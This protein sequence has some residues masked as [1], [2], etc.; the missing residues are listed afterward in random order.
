MRLTNKLIT[1]LI[2][3]LFILSGCS[4]INSITNIKFLHNLSESLNIIEYKVKEPYFKNISETHE[5][6]GNI[7]S[8]VEWSILNPEDDIDFND[9]LRY[10]FIYDTYVNLFE[11]KSYQEFMNE[12]IENDIILDNYQTNDIVSKKDMN[13]IINFIKFKMNNPI[14]EPINNIN[15]KEK[16]IYYENKNDIFN[17]NLKQGQLVSFKDNYQTTVKRINLDNNNIILDDVNL[18]EIIKDINIENN[19]DIDFSKSIIID[20]DNNVIK[21]SNIEL[22]SMLSNNFTYKGYY[23]SY[24]FSN[25]TFNVYISKN[26]DKLNYY[27]EF[28][29]YSINMAY[30]FR[31]NDHKINNAFLK[32]SYDSNIKTGISVGKYYD[33]FSNL[34]FNKGDNILE[35]VISSFQNQAELDSIKIP[36]AT[37]KI[38]VPGTVVC[39]IVLKLQVHLYANGKMEFSIINDNEVGFEIKNSNIR[40]INDI[41]T[42]LDFNLRSSANTSLNVLLGLQLMSK[43][44]I[45]LSL[46]TGIKGEA[47][48]I[49]HIYDN[50]NINSYNLDIPIDVLEEKVKDEDVSFCSDL[51]LYYITYL[52]FNSD[53]TLAYNLGFNKVI[54]ILDE[55]NQVFNNEFTHI[56]NFQF[57]K[58]CSK[59]KNYKNEQL[60]VL[61]TNKFVLKK[62]QYII[63]KDSIQNLN[64]ISIPKGYNK[65]DIIIEVDNP[66]IATVINQ[67]IKAISKGNTIINIRTN[68]NKYH[69]QCHI[70]V[71]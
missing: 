70:L 36:I 1:F 51:S 13:L 68:D 45:D 6:Y 54:N 29:L 52:E 32:L 27:G 43:D 4:K 42:D 30:K 8:L 31:T 62:Y 38:P 10:S 37:I 14:T 55:D 71:N 22:T 69:V 47:K 28:D 33:R 23:I 12:L 44:L 5:S 63:K 11:Y 20:N 50:N 7:Q 19:M 17:D 40:F 3:L 26:N 41:D 18:D 25:G 2:L 15:F 21:P 64:I 16:I 24:D 34:N 49:I 61:D 60:E 48:S 65:E 57:V 59:N 66:N 53:D 56:E 35:K 39:D 67:D 58:E 9:K 46:K